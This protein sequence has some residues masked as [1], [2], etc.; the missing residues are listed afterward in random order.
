MHL[1]SRLHDPLGSVLCC[2]TEGLHIMSRL[3]DPQSDSHHCRASPHVSYICVMH[4]L[5]GGQPV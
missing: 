1:P 4:G 2:L 3:L 5:G